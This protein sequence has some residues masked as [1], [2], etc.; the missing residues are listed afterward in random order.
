MSMRILHVTEVM[1]GGVTDF[2]ASITEKQLHESATVYVFY[3]ELK[4]PIQGRIFLDNLKGESNGSIELNHSPS[5]GI[6]QRLFRSIV[7]VFRIRRILLKTDFDVVHLHSS[8]AGLARIP[9]LLRGPATSLVFSPHGMS[10]LKSNHHSIVSHTFYQIE[11]YLAKQD[12]LF[13]C[14]SNSEAQIVAS[15]LNPRHKVKVI[16]NGVN[17]ELICNMPRNFPAGRFQ[18]AMIGRITY[19]KAPWVFNEIAGIC[20]DFAD[21]HWIGSEPGVP[22]KWLDPK[23]IEIVPWL[24]KDELIKQ[25]E[26]ID[27]LV[28]PTLWEGFPLSVALAQGRAIPALVSNAIGNQDVILHGTSGYICNSVPAYV[29]RIKQITRSKSLYCSLSIGSLTYAKQSLTNR[30]LGSQSIDLYLQYFNRENKS[31]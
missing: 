25:M 11:K 27:L 7:L 5:N 14:T 21:F 13:I 19:Q 16:T 24:S 30:H 6:Y 31:R 1:Q 29:E 17:E 12:A 2:I 20:K 4:Q 15:Q 9:T 26:R 3:P 23:N 28:H 18:I 8:F 10:F 22:I